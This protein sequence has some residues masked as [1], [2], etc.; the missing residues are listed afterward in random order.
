MRKILSLFFVMALCVVG[1]SAQGLV[2]GQPHP[3]APNVP[4]KPKSQLRADASFS[5]DDI[6]FWVGSGSK[7]AALVIEWH[8]GNQ[9]DAMVCGYRWD[10]EATGHDMIVAIAQADPR[11]VLL[12]QYT[13][14]M[15]YTIDGIGYGESRL[16]NSYDL[17]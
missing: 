10:G 5:F 1:L 17:E 3:S 8:D 12:T 14:W 6:Q 13:G 2:Q 11:L 7:R 4:V 9:P 16:N 15:G